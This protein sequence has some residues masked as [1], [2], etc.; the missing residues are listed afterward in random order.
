MRQRTRKLI[1]A[2]LLVVLVPFYCLLV[3][4]IAGQ[5]LGG[6]SIAVQTVF[7]AVTGLIWVLPAGALIWW[8]LRRDDPAGG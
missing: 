8:M 4:A 6:W 7:F 2:A 3:M 5:V 1:G